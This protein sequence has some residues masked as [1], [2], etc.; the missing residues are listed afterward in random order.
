MHPPHNITQTPSHTC[1]IPIT[2]HSFIQAW[3]FVR[4]GVSLFLVLS[5]VGAIMDEKGAGGLSGRMGMGSTVRQAEDSDKSFKV[6]PT[7]LPCI[8]YMSI[9][10]YVY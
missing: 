9:N 1:N 10:M 5:F 3:R 7:F 2:T 8:I 4:N 6:V